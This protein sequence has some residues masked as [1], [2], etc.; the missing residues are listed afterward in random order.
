MDTQ[1]P[2]AE[3]MRP[4]LQAMERSIDSARRARVKSPEPAA[5][6]PQPPTNEH[7][8]APP[9]RPELSEPV[10]ESLPRLKARPKHFP[11][12]FFAPQKHGDYRSRAG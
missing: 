11:S 1:K 7:V 6:K 5:A 10:E 8:P 9:Y 4:I 12:P 3:R 2:V